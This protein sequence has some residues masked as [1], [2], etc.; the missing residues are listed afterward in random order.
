MHH[1]AYKSGRLHCEDVALDAIAD[2]IGTPCYVYSTATL[3]RHARVIAEA[4][5][6]L[7]AL[8]AYSVKANGNLGVLATLA[9]AGCGADVV[10]AGEMQRALV[11]GIPARKIVFSGVGKTRSE[12]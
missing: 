3:L 5:D 1:F 12:M 2:E 7:N 11:A 8:I 10:S 6:G 4:F 9:K